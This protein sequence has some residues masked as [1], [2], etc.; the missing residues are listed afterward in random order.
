MANPLHAAYYA[1][2]ACTQRVRIVENVRL[3]RDTYRVRFEC[4]QLA[5]RITPGQFVMLR[6]A[7][8]NDPLLGPAA[9]AVRHRAVGRAIRPIGIDVVYLVL[10]KMTRRLARLFQARSW[11]SGGHWATAFRHSR[12]SI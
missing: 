2:R 5:Q 11:T 12:P 3:A 8:A 4:P 6:L 7:A 1:D 10:G 9:G